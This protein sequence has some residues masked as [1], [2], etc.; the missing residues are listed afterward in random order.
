M[1]DTIH[2]PYVP[3]AFT[4]YPDLTICSAWNGYWTWGGVARGAAPRS[5]DD[6]EGDPAR[7]G[8]AAGMS[9]HWLARTDE[10]PDG[11]LA[12]ASLSSGGYLAAFPSDGPAPPAER[13]IDARALDPEGAPGRAS[14]V[15]PPDGVTIAFDD[16]AVGGALRAVLTVPWPDVLS[17]LVVQSSRF[18]GADR[19]PRRRS[20]AT[21][22]GSVRTDLP[23][24]ARRGRARAARRDARAHRPCDPAVRRRE[25]VAVGPC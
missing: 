19:R 2:H 14:L 20:V 5:P 3:T 18:A 8:G 15:L 17:T 6:H 10:A 1:T 4:L 21:R 11:A 16:P 24:R 12:F 9:W 22:V 25:P 13:K 23:R 7:L